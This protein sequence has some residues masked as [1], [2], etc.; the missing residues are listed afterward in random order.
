MRMALSVQQWM[1]RGVLGLSAL[2]L[3]LLFLVFAWTGYAHLRAD[4][5]REVTTLVTMI[6][7]PLAKQVKNPKA[8]A[9]VLQTLAAKLEIRLACAHAPDGTFLA[10]WQRG[11]AA[12][13][14]APCRA[15]AAEDDGGWRSV[16]VE[17]PV[18]NAADV[19]VAAVT[20]LV[21]FPSLLD[22]FRLSVLAMLA[23]VMLFILISFLFAQRMKVMLL[24]P[25]RQIA[26]TA[27]RVSL[28][29]D[30]SLRVTSGALAIVPS[31]IQALID[32]FNTMLREIEDRDGK[33]L[34]KTLEI[35][36]ARHQAES[37]NIAKSQFLANIS[38]ELRTPLNAILGFSAMIK[39]QQ[40]GEVAQP[41]YLEYARDIH[42]SGQH[43]LTIINDVLDL[44]RAEAGKL[45]IHYE[46]VALPK[47]IQRAIHMVAQ[48]ASEGGVSITTEI[49]ERMP[50][51]V[52][53]KVRILQI[54]LNLLS[55]AVKFT[56]P[57]GRITVRAHAEEGVNGVFYFLLEVEDT[58]V[59]MTPQEV[60]TVF[61]SF[62]Q[63]DAGLD[64]KYQG[65]GLGL[66]LTKK[67]VEMHHGKITVKSE[68]GKGTTV[69]IRLVS[70][71][72][73]L[74]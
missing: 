38:H 17:V 57:G 28:Y 37:A 71:P 65:A 26:N 21:G 69:H 73:L 55:N 30:F 64:R 7:A 45:S 42:D 2:L 39:D 48:R 9:A 31:E 52:G 19:P 74:D 15:L 13:A 32:S 24:R 60:D 51:F 40:H 56:D 11:D 35:E 27:Q 50:K 53:D 4:G 5:V 29:K 25:V 10:G 43:L 46:L 66:P 22:H 14:D 3:L 1:Q 47:V 20:V 41:K 62:V 49:A 61:E 6:E 16:R 67:L 12:S 18:L 68:R 33:I 58:G 59:G 44:S 72:A 63:A 8:M 70:D 23:A 54:L 36:K 34:R